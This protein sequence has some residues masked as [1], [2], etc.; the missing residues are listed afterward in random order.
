[1]FFFVFFPHFGFISMSKNDIFRYR[2]EVP[3]SIDFGSMLGSKKVSIFGPLKVPNSLLF[4]Y[5][6][7]KSEN[8][9]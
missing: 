9:P 3:K 4:Y 5:T 8:L 7:A 2:F 1:M 6:S